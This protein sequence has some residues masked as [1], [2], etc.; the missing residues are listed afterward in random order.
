MYGME[1]MSFEEVI[2]TLLS[3]E[4]RLKGSESLGENSV[5]VVSGKRSFNRFR[6][7]LVRAVVIRV[8]INRI[9]KRGKVME[10]VWQEALKVT[11]T[12]WHGY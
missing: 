6:K 4:R 9:A 1:T 5:M 11:L 12:N 7:E 10:Q 2:S 3:E 8:I